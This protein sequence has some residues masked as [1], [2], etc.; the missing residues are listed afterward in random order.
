MLVRPH[1]YLNLR[2]AFSGENPAAIIGVV[3]VKLS[4][5]KPFQA[6]AEPEFSKLTLKCFDASI[7]L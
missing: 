6:A 3:Q 5:G 7:Y 2:F 4:Q 1:R